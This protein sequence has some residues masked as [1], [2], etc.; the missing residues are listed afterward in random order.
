MWMIIIAVAVVLVVSWILM[1]R[2]GNN[3]GTASD[4]I[5]GQV[6]DIRENGKK[7]YEENK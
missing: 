3:V 1:S 7:M 5:S 2:I 6:K 4:F